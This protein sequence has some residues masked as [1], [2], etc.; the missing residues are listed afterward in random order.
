[1]VMFQRQIDSQTEERRW[2]MEMKRSKQ[3]TLFKK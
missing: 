3:I 1:M 2:M